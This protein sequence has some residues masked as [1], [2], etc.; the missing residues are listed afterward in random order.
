MM[1]D[2]CIS[3]FIVNPFAGFSIPIFDSLSNDL[4]NSA[5]MSNPIC[6]ELG[7]REGERE[8]DRETLR[9]ST[10]SH[11]KFSNS[12]LQ[13]AI[14]PLEQ[15]SKLPLENMVHIRSNLNH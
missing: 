15:L 9:V 12:R 11:L 4:L 2:L 3:V 13:L 8:R 6:H 7:E 1:H 5:N 10:L 14:C